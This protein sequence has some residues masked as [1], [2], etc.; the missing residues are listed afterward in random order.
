MNSTLEQPSKSQEG[1]TSG[2]VGFI[3]GYVTGNIRYGSS[4]VESHVSSLIKSI[5][6]YQSSITS[7]DISINLTLEYLK[8]IQTNRPDEVLDLLNKAISELRNYVENSDWVTTNPDFKSYGKRIIY[9]FLALSQQIKDS[10][11]SSLVADVAEQNKG[12]FL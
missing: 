5:E 10:S 6:Q 9:H 4:I 11:F 8:K 2:L 7:T 1:S 12:K 3:N